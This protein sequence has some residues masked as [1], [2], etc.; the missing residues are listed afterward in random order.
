MQAK[1]VALI[2]GCD[3]Q[4]QLEAAWIRSLLAGLEVQETV[5]IPAGFL[6]EGPIVLVE[7]GLLRLER[8]LS[9][10]RL[11]Q[12]RYQR[13]Q[14]LEALAGFGGFVLIHLSDEEG[15]DGDELYPMLPKSTRVWRNFPYARFVHFSV[16]IR[17]FP[18]GPRAEFLGNLSCLP[19]EQRSY[20]W[21]FMGTIWGSGSRSLATSLFLRNLPQ[22][23]FFG[24]QRFGVGL[25]LAQ[26]QAVLAQSAFAL[27]PEGDRHLDTFRL[28]ESMQMGCVPLIMNFRNQAEMLLGPASPVPVFYEWCEAVEFA[29]FFL[30]DLKSLNNLQERVRHWWRRKREEISRAILSDLCSS[31]SDLPFG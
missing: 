6:A 5:G 14:R 18:I 10:D 20:P 19:A 26:Y 31:R 15:L 28:Y 22:G 9:Q 29:R 1:P 11:S 4:L 25:P 17:S 8:Q 2:W 24:G 16:L 23:M 13:A 12:L 30:N 21:A 7:S 27:C 3:P